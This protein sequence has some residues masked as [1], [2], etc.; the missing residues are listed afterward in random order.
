LEEL[1]SV[2]IA[3]VEADLTAEDADVAP[4]TEV[5]GHEGGSGTVLLE[6]NLAIKES[7]LRDTGVHLLVLG[8]HDGLVLKEVEDSDLSDSVVLETRLNNVLF[9]VTVESQD[10]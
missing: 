7:T 10:L 6:D 2:L 3:V 9:K 1:A 5:V 4:N 8:D